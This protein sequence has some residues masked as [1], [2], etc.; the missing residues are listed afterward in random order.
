MYQLSHIPSKPLRLK[1]DRR[2][3]AGILFNPILLLVFQTV[4]ALIVVSSGEMLSS[5]YFVI[6]VLPIGFAVLT[7]ALLRVKS[8]KLY[9]VKQNIYIDSALYPYI[10]GLII[11]ISLFN[12]SG[13]AFLVNY[14][15]GIQNALSN[16]GS[17]SIVTSLQEKLP[18]NISYISMLNY[19][20]PVLMSAVII[21]RVTVFGWFSLSAAMALSF[22]FGSLLG[23]RIIFLDIIVCL[24][25]LIIRTKVLNFKTIVRI[26]FL[27]SVLLSLLVYSQVSRIDSKSTIQG[28]NVLRSYYSESILNGA[29]VIERESRGQTLF[30]TLRPIFSI[31]VLSKIVGTREVYEGLFGSLPIKSRRDD[32]TYAAALGADP[33][34]NTFGI[35][36]YSYL[37]AGVW[38]VFIIVLVYITLTTLY[39]RFMLGRIDALLLYPIFYSLT[40]DQLRTNGIF[41]LRIAFCIIFA[42]LIL[43]ANRL[44]GDL[45]RNR[46]S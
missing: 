12:L 25:L 11:I 4:I 5:A 28:A 20:L 42:F 19:I 24:A 6:T 3:S 21:S 29:R 22:I 23:S 7:S 1:S 41:S 15:G 46:K 30:W 44:I 18:K 39:T 45:R 33:R 31:P 43:L 17:Q 36:G 16:A 26:G 14:Y 27:V 13:I 34:F 37:D 35:F 10:V 9:T 8:P 38:A 32:F 2:V 40:L